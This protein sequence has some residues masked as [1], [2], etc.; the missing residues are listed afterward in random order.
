MGALLFQV[1][2][3]Y[4]TQYAPYTWQMV[5]GGVLLLLIMFM[6]NGL[7]SLV[8]RFRARS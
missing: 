8:D 3:T 1:V 5:L 6:P 4:A 7:W 2:Q